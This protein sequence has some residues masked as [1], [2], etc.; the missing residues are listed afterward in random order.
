MATQNGQLSLLTPS[1]IDNKGQN[2]EHKSENS[3][4][5]KRPRESPSLDIN[6][7]VELLQQQLSEEKHNSKI[8]RAQLSEMRDQIAK[9]SDTIVELNKTISKLHKNETE[10]QKRLGKNK[11]PSKPSNQNNNKA[12]VKP[13]QSAPNIHHSNTHTKPQPIEP[14][15]VQQPNAGASVSEM[16]TSME[17]DR[18]NDSI[19]RITDD[20]EKEETH[21]ENNDD[22]DDIHST[23]SLSDGQR[24]DEQSETVTHTFTENEKVHRS[25]KI[26]PI[27]VWTE[28]QQAT[29][30]IIRH[31]MPNYSCI[32]T[33]INKS[34]MRVLSKT[35]EIRSAQEKK[36]QLQHIHTVRR[37]NAKLVVERHR[38]RRRTRNHRCT[39]RTWHC[40]A[41]RPT[42]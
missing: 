42:L 26:P 35:A 8:L 27:V 22:D 13:T 25:S 4:P 33:R 29:Q 19:K 11:S 12:A 30:Q 32:F 7:Y 21:T 41:Q 15:T 3:H 10:K 1:R 34:K 28:N 39:K 31:N 37:A 5:A 6:K 38:N 9:L 24:E 17:T 2:N 40:T 16:N 18:H 23:H 36:H 20:D 14:K